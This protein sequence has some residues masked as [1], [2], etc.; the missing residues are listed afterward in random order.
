MA[1]VYF[2]QKNSL[3][4][5]NTKTIENDNTPSDYKPGLLFTVLVFLPLILLSGYRGWEFARVYGDTGAYIGMFQINPSSINEALKDID[6]DSKYPG[7]ILFISFIKQFISNEYRVFFIIVAVV[8]GLSIALTYRYYRANVVLCAFLFF[9][10]T[11]YMS[12]MMNGVRQFLAV[13]ILFA[14]FPLIQKKKIAVFIV[15]ALLLFTIHRSALIVI[16]LYL[17]A[18]GKPFNKKT[19]IIL[20]LCLT[21][22]VFT[23]QFTNMMDDSLQNTAYSHMVSEFDGDDGTSILRALVYSVPAILAIAFRRQISDDTPGIIKISINMSLFTAGLY[24]LSVPISGIYMGRVPIYF[25]LFNYILLPWELKHFFK[26]NTY[27]I[28]SIAMIILYFLF[29]CFQM[30]EWGI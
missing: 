3:L 19:L 28:L 26:E 22:I 16:P 1:F 13:S 23:G 4:I 7:F 2:Q 14:C 12:W 9:A 10:S 6:W 21:A 20:L 24:F 15:I 18:L 11:D 30:H 29:Y 8:Q 17:A 25:S 27:K 5:S